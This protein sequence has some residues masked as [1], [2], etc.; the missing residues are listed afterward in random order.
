[1]IG[2]VKGN[3]QSAANG[4]LFLSMLLLA[5]FLMTF[6]MRVTNKE[7][8]QAHNPASREAH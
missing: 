5:G 4:L 1:M 3:S 7:A 6:F 8:P 2:M